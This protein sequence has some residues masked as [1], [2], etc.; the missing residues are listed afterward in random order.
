[1]IPNCFWYLVD[2]ETVVSSILKNGTSSLVDMF[3]EKRPPDT[4]KD[5][6]NRIA[7]VRHPMDRLISAYSYLFGC[8]SGEQTWENF[9]DHCL[10]NDNAHWN[11]QHPQLVYRG[12]FLPTQIIRLNEI[13]NMFPKINHLNKV[14][15]KKTPLYRYSDLVYKYKDD[16]KMWANTYG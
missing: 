12:D 9:I 3:P 15:W 6:K 10:E 4:I 14:K 1:M 13:R 2:D 11:P 16:I 8:N 5:F 7:V